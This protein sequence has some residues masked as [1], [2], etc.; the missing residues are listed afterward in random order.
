MAKTS[1]R[2]RWILEHGTV[3]EN[4]GATRR[5]N[6]RQMVEIPRGRT[7]TLGNE[8]GAEKKDNSGGVVL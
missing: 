1:W 8:E 3:G 7:S 5:V 2:V 4:V 6:R